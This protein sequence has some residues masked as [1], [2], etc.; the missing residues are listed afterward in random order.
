MYDFLFEEPK[1]KHFFNFFS[2]EEIITVYEEPPSVDGD[3]YIRVPKV[4]D[5]DPKT[6]RIDRET[7]KSITLW[8]EKMR[9]PYK[10]RVESTLHILT[11]RRDFAIKLLLDNGS[12]CWNGQNILTCLWSPLRMSKHSPEGLQASKWHDSLLYK[13]KEYIAEFRKSDPDMTVREYRRLTSLIFRQLLINNG[14]NEIKACI[15]SW[16]VDLW[17]IIS[18]LWWGIK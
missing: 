17:Q 13:K 7:G 2:K 4:E 15:M 16:F 1:K 11:S 9:Y 8:E 12:F 18:P 10:T 6:M 5:K 3:P 14:V